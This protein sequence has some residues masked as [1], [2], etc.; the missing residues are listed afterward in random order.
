MEHKCGW[1]ILILLHLSINISAQELPQGQAPLP[2]QNQQGDTLQRDPM[3]LD[4]P[5]LLPPRGPVTVE[6]LSTFDTLSIFRRL[7]GTFGSF[8]YGWQWVN[9]SSLNNTLVAF[10]MPSFQGTGA[11]VGGS[12]FRLIDCWLVGA[13]A[14]MVFLTERPV[15]N[16]DASIVAGHLFLKGGYRLLASSNTLLFPLIG[17]GGGRSTLRISETIN[18]GISFNNALLSP[19]PQINISTGSVLFDISANLNYFTKEMLQSGF[20]F[21]I[22]AGYIIAVPSSGWYLFNANVSEGPRFMLGGPYLRLKFGGGMF[23]PF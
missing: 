19:V 10:S 8:S 14:N 18:N 17:V 9:I 11:T 7:N 16:Y 3:M 22:S 2:E 1:I 12:A 6:G 13:D 23:K 5:P 4:Q 20:H 21:G 15:P